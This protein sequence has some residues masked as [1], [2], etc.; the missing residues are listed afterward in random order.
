MIALLNKLLEQAH[1]I[2]LGLVEFSYDFKR[3]SVSSIKQERVLCS[4]K[5]NRIFQTLS[6]AKNGFPFVGKILSSVDKL[7]AWNV[8]KC[9]LGKGKVLKNWR[10]FTEKSVPSQYHLRP[11]VKVEERR[12]Y[13]YNI[14]WSWFQVII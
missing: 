10:P 8:Y 13:I 6:L 7:T 14:F 2:L 4:Y 1:Q 5:Q 12:I 9:D 11:L 3:F